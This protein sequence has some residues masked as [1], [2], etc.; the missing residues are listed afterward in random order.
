MIWNINRLSLLISLS[1]KLL[2]FMLLLLLQ[3]TRK[4]EISINSQS[5]SWEKFVTHNSKMNYIHF[6]GTELGGFHSGVMRR[7]VGKKRPRS[8]MFYK[9]F[10]T[11]QVNAQIHSHLKYK[12]F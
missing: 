1:L 4:V 11:H 6:S 3:T 10:L 8:F 7:G 9:L 2:S 12:S 5:V